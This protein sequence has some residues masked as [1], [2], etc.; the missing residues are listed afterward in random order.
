MGEMADY[1]LD[2]MFDRE[3]DEESGDLVDDC[4][5]RLDTVKTKSCRYC[6]KK[7]LTWG[8]V[9]GKWRLFDGATLHS[10]TP[11]PTEAEQRKA[12]VQKIIEAL[13]PEEI[14]ELTS[15]FDEQRSKRTLPPPAGYN[16]H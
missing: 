11:K 15:W 7:N 3:W 8:Q 2:M 9:N 6:G 1:Y 10:C 14:D 16:R 12:R 4:G 5:M 13:T